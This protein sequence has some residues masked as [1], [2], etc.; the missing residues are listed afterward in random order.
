MNGRRNIFTITVSAAVI[1]GRH[2]THLL[3][4]WSCQGTAV[5]QLRTDLQHTLAKL[6]SGVL[7]KWRWVYAN[8]RGEGPEGTLFIYDH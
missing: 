6:S 3:S 7:L 2:H 8:G 4:V 1:Y 5:S